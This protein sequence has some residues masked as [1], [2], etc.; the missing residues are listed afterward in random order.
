MVLPD[1]PISP[2]HSVTS[3][4]QYLLMWVSALRALKSCTSQIPPFFLATA[5]I[6]LLYLLRAGSITPS[7]SHLMTCFSTSSMCASGILNC[8]TK[9]GL[10]VFNVISCR[11]V[12]HC[13]R[14]NQSSLIASWNFSNTCRYRCLCS[15]GTSLQNFSLINF[16][17]VSVNGCFIRVSS[18]F[19]DKLLI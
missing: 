7:L 8:L 17:L 16:C 1:R 15:A 12:L 18:C 3:L 9:I 5:K 11:L 2:T 14:S 4:M 19:C 6:G 10:L 13:P